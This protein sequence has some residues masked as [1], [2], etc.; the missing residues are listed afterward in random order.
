MQEKTIF[1]LIDKFNASS[2][3]SLELESDGT[4]VVLRREVHERGSPMPRP[5]N[6]AGTAA[7]D[8]SVF[9][10]AGKSSLAISPARVEPSAAG[11]VTINSPIVAAFY[12][13]GEPD[14]PPFVKK[15][16]KVKAGDTLCI[17]EAM[18][19]MNRLLAE[20]DCEILDVMAASGD[21]VEYGQPLFEVR[22][23]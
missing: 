19:M 23:L 22:K 5:S 13:S 16:G 12:A 11:S 2:M 20:F 6:P 15:G 4:K 17:L 7:D 21:L 3:S 18:K 9:A 1:D 8:P 10:P 14:T